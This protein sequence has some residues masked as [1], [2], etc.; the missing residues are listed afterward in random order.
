MTK[1]SLDEVLEPYLR[2]VWPKAIVAWNRLLAGH[3]RD[4]LVGRDVLIGFALAGA[5]T[6]LLGPLGLM[7]VSRE[8]IPPVAQV[9]LN[10]VRGGRFALGE[11]FH[12]LLGPLAL[13]FLQERAPGDDEIL[14]RLLVLDDPEGVDLS[15]VN[16]GISGEPGVD[17]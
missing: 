6:V 3:F 1:R 12:T 4:P 13:L 2:R 17:L 7:A 16:R 10:A 14:P 8:W 5:L 11:V 15:F 9:P